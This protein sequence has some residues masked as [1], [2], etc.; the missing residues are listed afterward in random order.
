MERREGTGQRS[1]P[2]ESE[3][4]ARAYEIYQARNG[5]PGDPESDWLQAERELLLGPGTPQRGEPLLSDVAPRRSSRTSPPVPVPDGMAL[6]DVQA[7][8][9]TVR[10]GERK[11]AAR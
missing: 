10:R 11:S 9:R 7:A 4:R 1:G 2:T 5:E 3:I 8:G 6:E